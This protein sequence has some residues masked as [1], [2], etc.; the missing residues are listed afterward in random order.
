MG[1][2]TLTSRP[3]K[4]LAPTSSRSPTFARSVSRR[5]HFDFGGPCAT[6][7]CA[8]V[9]PSPQQDPT[10]R[11]LNASPRPHPFTP[12]VFQKVAEGQP[13]RAGAP[14]S[15]TDQPRPSNPQRVPQWSPCCTVTHTVGPPGKLLPRFAPPSTQ[16]ADPPVACSSRGCVSA[17]IIHHSALANVADRDLAKMN[18]AKRSQETAFLTPKTPIRRKRQTQSKPLL[19]GKERMR[20]GGSRHNSGAAA[21]AIQN[22]PFAIIR[23]ASRDTLR[24]FA[25]IFDAHRDR[26]ARFPH[27]AFTIPGLPSTMSPNGASFRSMKVTVHDCDRF[28]S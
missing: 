15:D 3:R 13:R 26:V 12:K 5:C 23:S 9:T 24:P 25:P 14:P 10:L 7:T 28:I 18:A 1:K 2:R 11:T 21:F 6:S 16:F 4:P 8:V 27:S 22:S 20:K 19:N 17:F